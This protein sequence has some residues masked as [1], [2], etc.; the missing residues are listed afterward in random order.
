MSTWEHACETW[1]KFGWRSEGR[2]A[3]E[4]SDWLVARNRQ[5][6]VLDILLNLASV[7]LKYLLFL[8]GTEFVRVQVVRLIKLECWLLCQVSCSIIYPIRDTSYFTSIH[9]TKHLQKIISVPSSQDKHAPQL[10]YVA[11][12]VAYPYY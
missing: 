4:G 1:S 7:K 5:H 11:I 12:I 10:S 9:F 2:E 8:P 6:S 3:S